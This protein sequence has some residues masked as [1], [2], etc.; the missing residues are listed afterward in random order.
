VAAATLGEGRAQEI[1]RD[2]GCG[3][4]PHGHR[5]RDSAEI[6]FGQLSDACLK[7]PTQRVALTWAISACWLR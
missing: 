4:Q 6:E 3:G 1:V 2:P 7:L 5:R